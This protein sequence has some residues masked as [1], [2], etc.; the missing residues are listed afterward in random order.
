MTRPFFSAAGVLSAVCALL[1]GVGAAA[2]AAAAADN[3]KGASTDTIET[4]LAC[5]AKAKT[6]EQKGRC[7]ERELKLVET[8]HKDAV[9]RVTVV[10][11]AW[12]KPTKTRRRWDAFLRS[13]Q[14]FE[15]FVKRECAFVALTTKGN[16]TKEENAELACRIGYY[17][18]HT[19]VLENH[20]LGAAR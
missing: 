2:P 9:E 18:M 11:K 6:D 19:D 8:E 4:I 17:R 16:R 14:S 10:A 12:D 5:H 15:T 3:N 7:L 20:Y 1:L 13:S